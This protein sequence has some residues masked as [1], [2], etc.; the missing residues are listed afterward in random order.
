MSD[1]STVKFPFSSFVTLYSLE[2]SHWELPS[3]SSF[4]VISLFDYTLPITSYVPGTMLG[5]RDMGL[6]K[7]W[8]LPSQGI[9]GVEDKTRK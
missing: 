7:T 2:R 5:P 6:H 8:P 1:F 4:G 3:P 9:Q